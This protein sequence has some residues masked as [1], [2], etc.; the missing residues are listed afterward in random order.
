L[1]GSIGK[2]RPP[3]TRGLVPLTVLRQ[4]GLSQD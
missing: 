1:P 2:A 3:G 4:M